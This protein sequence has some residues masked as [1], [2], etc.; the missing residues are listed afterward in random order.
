MFRSL[1]SCSHIVWLNKRRLHKSPMIILLVT[2]VAFAHD[3]IYH[4]HDDTDNASLDINVLWLV[5]WQSKSR[6]NRLV[7]TWL[8]NSQ[9]KS[10]RKR[11]KVGNDK[12]VDYI[13]QCLLHLGRIP[14]KKRRQWWRIILICIVFREWSVDQISRYVPVVIPG[15]DTKEKSTKGGHGWT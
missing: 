3:S 7:F 1:I 14:S 8:A 6:R 4:F 10:H 11:M 5:H 9:P 2:M 12:P 13:Y 15:R